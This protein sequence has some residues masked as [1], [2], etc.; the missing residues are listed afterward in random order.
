M[1]Y[2]GFCEK[3]G[4]SLQDFCL[5]ACRSGKY[6]P[7][8]DAVRAFLGWLSEMKDVELGWEE[9][10]AHSPSLNDL[11][12]HSGENRGWKRVGLNEMLSEE[13]PAV[14]AAL[15]RHLKY[16]Q[17][18]LRRTYLVSVWGNPQEEGPKLK[19]GNAALEYLGY[20][21]ASA[22]ALLS[23]IIGLFFVI[24][25][26]VSANCSFFVFCFWS[27]ILF[28]SYSVCTIA[29]LNFS[30]TAGWVREQGGKEDSNVASSL[31][32]LAGPGAVP[33]VLGCWRRD[34][35]PLPQEPCLLSWKI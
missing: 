23:N 27:C 10:Q 28:S 26:T 15:W 5:P 32:R 8:N 14:P 25:V 20:N 6:R 1:P 12:G 30:V 9:R 13:I 18:V 11:S 35:L 17:M 16:Q 29:G 34:S 2:S 4:Q 22:T 33:Q 7:V 3:G 31:G 21:R 24:F 19:T